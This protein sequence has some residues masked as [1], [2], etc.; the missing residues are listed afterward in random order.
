GTYHNDLKQ[1]PNRTRAQEA[2]VQAMF[3]RPTYAA[4]G[5]AR[6]AAY[7]IAGETSRARLKAEKRKQCE[8]FRDVFA[9]P[10]RPVTLAPPSPSDPSWRLPLAGARATGASANN[11]FR[12][13]PILADAREDAGCNNEDVLAHCRS[14]HE[15]VR[16]CWVVDECLG[17]KVTD[18]R[19]TP[20]MAAD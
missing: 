1:H 18:R 11:A 10:F 2:V 7:A 5:A 12:A 9:T 17:K 19:H 6:C 15:H 3:P 13:L 14:S 4:V 8:L 16:G 20:R